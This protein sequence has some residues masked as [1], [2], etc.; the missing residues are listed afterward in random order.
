M[1]VKYDTFNLRVSL[2]MTISIVLNLY[3]VAWLMFIFNDQG[4]TPRNTDEDSWLSLSSASSSLHLFFN[5]SGVQ[6]Q[7]HQGFQLYLIGAKLRLHK[8]AEVENNIFYYLLVF[9]FLFLS[10]TIFEA[11]VCLLF[12]G[13]FWSQLER[14]RQCRNWT[15]KSHYNNFL[16]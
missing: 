14:Y 8:Y 16:L 15:Q 5:M 4:E 11:Q 1:W 7:T 3:L 2:S 13:N 6:A 10:F 9:T 12:R